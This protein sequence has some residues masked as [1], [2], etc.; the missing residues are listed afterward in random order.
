MPPFFSA[1]FAS[2]AS[3]F[4]CAL[5]FSAGA[6]SPPDGAAFPPAAAVEEGGAAESS[7]AVNH[8]ARPFFAAAASAAHSIKLRDESMARSPRTV[9]SGALVGSESP[10]VASAA[11]TAFGA[12]HAVAIIGP[13]VRKATASSKAGVPFKLA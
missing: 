9:P 10:A 7:S 5:V 11:A 13:E 3:F 1:F 6:A 2:L 8:S 4:S 12:S